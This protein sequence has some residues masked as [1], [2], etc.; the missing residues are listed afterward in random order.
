M[1]PIAVLVPVLALCA[2]T[3]F[4]ELDQT[5]TT[6]VSEAPYPDLLPLS[7]LLADRAPTATREEAAALTGRAEALRRRADAL[8]G[9]VIEPEARTRLETGVPRP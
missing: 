3:Q 2:C 7:A 9:D 8:R 6:G 5:A 4:P 1:R